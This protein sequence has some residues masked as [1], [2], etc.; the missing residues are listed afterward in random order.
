MSAFITVGGILF[1][2][3]CPSGANRETESQVSFM[4]TLGGKRKAF[5]RPGGRRSWSIDVGIAPPHEVATIE[6]VARLGRI[7]GWYGP[8]SA[9]G[10][11]LS[12]E[13]SNFDVTPAGVEAA[14]LVQLPDGS[15]ANSVVHTGGG[16]VSVGRTH[17]NFEAVPVRPGAQVTVGAWGFNGV[18]FLG[19][20]RD[21][22][23]VPIGSYSGPTGSGAGWVWREATVTA[24]VGAAYM[25][26]SLAGGDRYARPSVSWG[27]KGR[28]AGGTGCPSAVIY[29]PAHSPVSLFDG[30]N[31]TSTAYQVMEVG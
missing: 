11:L 13:S 29:S 21:A 26:L 14:G 27:V 15:V 20:W 9:T 3:G 31:F 25:S 24:P 4:R 2:L 8:E 28:N 23:H 12:P 6:T 5:M 17:G 1:E 30:A 7:V 19:S 18:R 16:G 10:N 22:E